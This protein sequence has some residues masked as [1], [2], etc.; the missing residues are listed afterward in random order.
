MKSVIAILVAAGKN[1]LA[2]LIT[3]R[4][5]FWALELAASRT[6]TKVDDHVVALVKSA[7]E[8]DDAGVRQAIEGLAHEFGHPSTRQAGSG[9]SLSG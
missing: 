5:V 4:M 7:Y 6:E 9:S 3:K 1:L 8:N 2:M